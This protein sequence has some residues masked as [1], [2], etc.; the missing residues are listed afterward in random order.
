M[1]I[2]SDIH[3][4]TENRSLHDA[5][6][7]AVENDPDRTLIVAGDFTK[8]A[9]SKEYDRTARWLASIMHK[10]INVVVTVG[11]HDMSQSILVARVPLK[12]GYRR[13]SRLMDMLSMQDC[14]VARRDCFDAVYYS[15]LRKLES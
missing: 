4:S 12:K 3:D 8:R 14:V 2:A 7:F 9:G 10:G 13:F 5:L 11:N 6:E 15:G 1:I